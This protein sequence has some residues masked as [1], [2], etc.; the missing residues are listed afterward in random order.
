M[1]PA[2]IAV[3]IPNSLARLSAAIADGI[4][5]AGLISH[6]SVGT[7]TSRANQ[8]ASIGVAKIKKTSK[9]VKDQIK[10][11]FLNFIGVPKTDETEIYHFL[12]DDLPDM[13][14]LGFLEKM[15][16]DRA[17]EKIVEDMAD[18]VHKLAGAVDRVLS[19]PG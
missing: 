5:F 19:N 1:K 6:L 11:Q 8:S 15:M 9:E 18:K 17:R 13:N 2:T 16:N 7:S 14:G 12:K 10:E 4:I 3:C